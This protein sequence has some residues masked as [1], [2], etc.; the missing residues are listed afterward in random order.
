M[1]YWVIILALFIISIILTKNIVH[2]VSI[3][4]LIWTVIMGLYQLNIGNFNQISSNTYF[5]ICS[6]IV[7]F[8]VG[9]VLFRHLIH[10]RRITIGKFRELPD[11]YSDEVIRYGFLKF[12]CITSII[13]LIPEAVNSL[14]VLAGGGTFETL[15]TN[16]SNGYS[17]LDIGVLS[18]Y[19]NYIVKPFCYIIYP[20]CAVDF[21]KGGRKR[22]LLVC[23]LIIA[24]LSTL[25]EGGRVQ[26]VYLSIHFLLIMKMAGLQIKVSKKVKRIIIGLITLM[27]AVVAY[28]T[29][30]RGTSSTLSQS[31][32]LYISG[33][34][35]LL[36][37]H[38]SALGF[39][40]HYTYGLVAVSGFLKP[41]FAL[42]ENIGFPYP[43]FLTNIQHVFEVE[44]T[45]S[46]GSVFHMN[47]YVSIFYYFF[48][49]GGYIGNIIEMFL[50]GGLSWLIYR[51][52]S[53]L[54]GMVY[55]A[56][57]FQGLLFSMIRFQFTISHYCLAFILAY[58]IFT[59]R[60]SEDIEED[61]I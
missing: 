45:I 23:T 59:K 11:E 36:D 25:Y 27:V 17:A 8:V 48:Y 26:F 6:G 40:P 18:I 20:L 47:A 12:L 14:Q 54:R 44:Q 37:S 5:I 1:F 43:A 13:V 49:D 38:L 24:T 58:F 30:S 2:P 41:F 7:A 22:W 16:Y 32:L 51:R 42:L 34:V 46:I 15:R 19:R 52:S 3:F 31:M 61:M 39:H 53:S 4:T 60:Y 50:Y 21:V 29:T 56:L 55:Y 57:L 33:C 28:I 10:Y 9:F 35:P